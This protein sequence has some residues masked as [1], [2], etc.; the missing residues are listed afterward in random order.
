M[1]G[2]DALVTTITEQARVYCI[3]GGTI[4]DN[5]F[6]TVIHGTVYHLNDDGEIYYLGAANGF[7]W[8]MVGSRVRNLRAIPYPTLIGIQSLL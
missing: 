7:Q 4:D 8:G 1:N 3:R 5:Q 6:I 2:K